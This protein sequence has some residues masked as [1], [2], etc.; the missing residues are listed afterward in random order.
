M[1]AT[2]LDYGCIEHIFDTKTVVENCMRMA[3][4]GGLYAVHTPVRNF[5]WHGLHTFSP[6]MIP[7]VF[8]VNGFQLIYE[9]YTT[10]SG[11]DVDIYGE[12][13]VDTIGW[14]VG[15]K[16]ESIKYFTSPEQNR[17]APK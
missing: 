1:F 14:Y 5:A 15:R 13:S 11:I 8:K 3:K 9:R 16:T 6:E 7:S 10:S 4:V 17:Y 12:E 2:V